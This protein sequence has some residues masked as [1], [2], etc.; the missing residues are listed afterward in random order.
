MNIGMPQSWLILTTLL[1]STASL[2]QPL[3]LP[4]GIKLHVPD[5]WESMPSSI[6]TTH[7][8][9]LVALRYHDGQSTYDCGLQRNLATTNAPYPYV[10]IHV[11]NTGR[12]GRSNL[13]EFTPMRTSLAATVA[14]F[15]H[16][17]TLP[18]KS[19]ALGIFMYDASANILW[20]P[21][22]TFSPEN[23]PLRSI[24]ALV[25]TEQGVVHVACYAKAVDFAA[26]LPIFE[27]IIRQMEISP[28]LSYRHR[29]SDSHPVLANVNWRNLTWLSSV[30]LALGV[31]SLWLVR[32]AQIQP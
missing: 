1:W 14:S 15:E 18:L 29:F 7:S 31:G 12:I 25:I 5:G 30:I 11:K 24:L 26:C 8:K 6:L 13:S 32:R 4:S 20:L 27:K 17:L 22:A 19:A 10:L 9:K 23:E 21:G 3:E 16:T 28:N 2:C